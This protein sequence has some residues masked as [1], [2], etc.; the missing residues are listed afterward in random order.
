[1]L[2][3]RLMLHS[4]SFKACLSSNKSMPVSD[5][6]YSCLKCLGYSHETDKCHIYRGLKPQS[7]KDRA[8][9]PKSLLMQSAFRLSLEPSYLEWVQSTSELVRSAL[10]VLTESSSRPL[11]VVSKKRPHKSPIDVVP[12]PLKFMVSHQVEARTRKCA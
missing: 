6:D 2:S 12:K 9:S 1:M 8:A 11:L 10:P 5:P 4:P 3:I 7:K